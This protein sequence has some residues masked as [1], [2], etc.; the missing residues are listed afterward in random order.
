MNKPIPNCVQNLITNLK[1]IYNACEHTTGTDPIFSERVT[2]IMETLNAYKNK[3]NLEY[4]IKCLSDNIEKVSYL[5][6][7]LRSRIVTEIFTP[8]HGVDID[9]LTYVRRY[10]KCVP[11]CS[12]KTSAL[13]LFKNP[14][15]H[16]AL[17]RCSND[18]N[19]LVYENYRCNTCYMQYCPNCWQLK[20]ENHECNQNDIETVKILM[21]TSVLCPRCFIPIC[22]EC[23][24]DHVKCSKCE[25]KFNMRTAFNKQ[26]KTTQL[27]ELTQIIDISYCDKV[28]YANNYPFE[29]NVLFNRCVYVDDTYACSLKLPEN[30]RNSDD[31]TNHMFQT[32]EHHFD[33]M[34]TIIRD[35][36]IRG[37]NKNRFKV[38]YSIVELKQN[39]I[40][41]EL[42]ASQIA[43]SI[44][45]IF[46]LCAI[47]E[48]YE[49]YYTKCVNIRK[50]ILKNNTNLSY[51]LNN[52]TGS[53][54]ELELIKFVRCYG[55]N[56]THQEYKQWL[57]TF[58]YDEPST[59]MPK[60]INHILPR[61][62]AMLTI[63]RINDYIEQVSS[64]NFESL[65]LMNKLCT[66]ICYAQACTSKHFNT[67]QEWKQSLIT[68]RVNLTIIAEVFDINNVYI[69]DEDD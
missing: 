16:Y 6:P 20:D 2:F 55:S 8:L 23:G 30:L 52:M 27:S 14:P 32:F 43:H 60:L 69:P 28:N 10:L 36:L 45:K 12:D 4:V 44:S 62:L 54:D 37:V 58:C 68:T 19:G 56:M 47:N 48:V 17:F 39:K 25:T 66:L 38:F 50:T 33:N 21:K 41:R 13:Q 5:A 59:Y 46:Q 63:T 64:S 65:K 26:I 67:T 15:K 49:D 61:K 29:C 24:C 1:T 57:E 7:Y 40:S 34:T 18:C 53:Q 11:N 35:E 42:C 22:K 9:K 31:K 51:M 3:P